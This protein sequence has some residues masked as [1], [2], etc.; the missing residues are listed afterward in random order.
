MILLWNLKIEEGIK[1]KQMENGISL[2]N[3][4][5][6]RQ[7]LSK[8]NSEILRSEGAHLTEYQ[9][10]LCL[11][12]LELVHLLFLVLIGRVHFASE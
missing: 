8:S 12:V 1:M 4:A 11:S 6:I 3:P 9:A 2:L 5:T 10:T 7:S